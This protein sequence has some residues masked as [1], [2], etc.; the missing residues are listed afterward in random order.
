M[1]IQVTK[2]LTL[3][4]ST[5]FTQSLLSLSFFSVN[6]QVHYAQ[7]FSKHDLAELIKRNHQEFLQDCVAYLG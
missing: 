2:V 4:S 1:L 6:T 3:S 5:T 7:L